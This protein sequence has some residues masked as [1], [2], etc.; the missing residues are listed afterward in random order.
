MRT[1]TRTTDLMEVIL[2]VSVILVMVS[3]FIIP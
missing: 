2:N 3:A 1:A